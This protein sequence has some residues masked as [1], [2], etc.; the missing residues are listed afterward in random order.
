M[1][2][3]KTIR[4]S[5]AKLSVPEY[6]LRKMLKENRLPGVYFGSRFMVNITLLEEMLREQSLKQVTKRKDA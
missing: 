3:L 5:A 6:R 2:V 4:Q 1:P